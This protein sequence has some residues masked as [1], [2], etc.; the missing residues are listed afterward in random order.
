MSA[1]G[2]F[3]GS[4]SGQQRWQQQQQHVVCLRAANGGASSSTGVASS[5]V[6]TADAEAI[7]A[8]LTDALQG[9]DRGIFGVKAA[10]KE[11][12]LSLIS[13]LEAHNPLP[14]PTN[15]LDLV[16]GD[17]TLLFSTI[18]IQGSKRTKLGLREVVTVGPLVQ[19]ID[20][21]ASTASNEVAFAVRGLALLKGS[22]TIEASYQ[23]ESETRVSITF[24]QSSLVPDQLQR[25][26][27]KNYDLL[28][29]IFNPEGWLDITY[30]DATHR[31]GRD[32]KGNIFYL[33]RSNNAAS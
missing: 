26:F 28:L 17:W 12:I 20:V 19:R 22:F 30:V 11:Q 4:F 31:V 9:L 10:Q 27:E 18:T 3:R 13:Q 8:Q 16:G 15:H 1:D 6:P 29:S 33:V 23:A 5:L 7:K 25:L 24:R 2:T 14:D 32:D 21:D